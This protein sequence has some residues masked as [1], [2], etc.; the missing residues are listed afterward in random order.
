MKWQVNI[1]VQHLVS[2]TDFLESDANDI[3]WADVRLANDEVRRWFAILRRSRLVNKSQNEYQVL[4]DIIDPDNHLEQVVYMRTLD[5]L[6][7]SLGLRLMKK[8]GKIV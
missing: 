4:L 5:A 1:L 7:Q 8:R 6:E 3:S 2:L